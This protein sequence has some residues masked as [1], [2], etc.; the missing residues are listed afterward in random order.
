MDGR[1]W[2]GGLF[3]PAFA[4]SDSFDRLFDG[5]AAV[6]TELGIK[7][8]F[9]YLLLGKLN[10][11]V[12]PVATSVKTHTAKAVLDVRVISGANGELIRS[13]TESDERSDFTIDDAKSEAVSSLYKRIC[14]PGFVRSK[15]LLEGQ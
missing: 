7:G 11:N 13:W 15:V 9:K 12:E 8:R 14:A 2:T 1:R 10:T 4:S 3:T 5:E 6:F